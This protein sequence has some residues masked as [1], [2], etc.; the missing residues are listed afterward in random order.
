MTISITPETQRLLEE[1][2]KKG[3]YSG[4]DDV[5]RLALRTLNEVEGE[6]IEDLDEET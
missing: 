6:S 4:A 3:G 5:V 2:M 1:D